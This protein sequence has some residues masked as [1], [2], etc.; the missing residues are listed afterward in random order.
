MN[1]MQN[2]M[3]GGVYSGGGGDFSYVLCY[4]VNK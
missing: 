1:S 4:Y 2:K 3:D